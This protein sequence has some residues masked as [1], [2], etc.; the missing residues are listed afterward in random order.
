LKIISSI[1]HSLSHLCQIGPKAGELKPIIIQYKYAQ[2]ILAQ[3]TLADEL[4]GI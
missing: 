1:G 3:P 2:F 4:I